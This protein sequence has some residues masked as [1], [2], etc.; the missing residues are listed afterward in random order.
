MS[1]GKKGAQQQIAIAERRVK[2]LSLRKAGASYRAIGE[3]LG[4]SYQTASEDIA[5]GLK[6][7]AAEQRAETAELRALEAVRL[8]ALQAACWQQAMNGNLKAVQTAVRIFERRARLL[9]LDLQ[10]GLELPSD[11]D[12]ILRWHNDNQRIIDVTPAADDHAAAAPQLTADDSAAPGALSYRVRW[13][14]LGQEPISGDAELE[15]G[16]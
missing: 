12:I 2:A 6:E 1:V 10:P 15:D 14:T 3:R 7:L 5:F 8:D 9:G 11:L 4:V 13:A 16:A